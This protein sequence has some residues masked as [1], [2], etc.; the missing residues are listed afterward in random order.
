DHVRQAARKQLYAHQITLLIQERLQLEQHTACARTPA[1]S[2]LEQFGSRGRDHEQRPSNAA[3]YVLEQV[4]KLGLRPMDVLDEHD[5]GPL[6]D[7]LGQE[8]C[9]GVLEAV[10]RGERVQVAGDVEAEREAENLPG[11]ESVEREFGRVAFEEA[12]VLLQHL[13]QRPIRGS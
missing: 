7:D 8:L 6:T 2:A 4:Q 1:R 13:A 12:Q 5:R 10:A 3:E 11:A 9:P